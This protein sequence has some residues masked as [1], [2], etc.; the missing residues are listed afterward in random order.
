MIRWKAVIPVSIIIL[1]VLIGYIVFI[2]VIVKNIIVGT[3]QKITK[4]K[5]DVDDVTV[6]L[7]DSSVTIKGFAAARRDDPWKNLCEIDT[8]VIDLRL[9]ALFS[10]S[11]IIDELSAT[12]VRWGTTRTTSGALPV[13]IQK[14]EKKKTKK[15][16][17]FKVTLPL[18]TLKK[19]G[20]KIDVTQLVDVDNLAVVKQARNIETEIEQKKN[21]WQNTVKKINTY[22]Q[23][24]KEVRNNIKELQSIKKIESVQDVLAAQQAL[25]A[26]Q[27]DTKKLKELKNDVTE[28]RERVQN[29]VQ[30]LK[31]R[32]NELNEI[33]KKD[34]KEVFDMLGIGEIGMSNVGAALFGPVIVERITTLLDWL[35]RVRGWL[36]KKKEKK[37]IQ[38]RKRLKGRDIIFP[39]T[40]QENPLPGLLVH[41]LSFSGE[42]AQKPETQTLSLS[43]RITDITSNPRLY[44]KPIRITAQGRIPDIKNSDVSITGVMDY[45][46][47]LY[48]ENFQFTVKEY[49]LAD[50]T[51]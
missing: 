23:E 44:G 7:R 4:A 8:A 5:V 31:K 39:K 30:F 45:T 1:L 40:K 50:M 21:S 26:V 29:D 42:S 36:P 14:E 10:K 12:G 3:G 41:T 17:K 24:I 11:I 15:K 27:Q 35:D 13:T 33:K 2:D 32:I 37:K 20:K 6:R 9:M 49:P 48:R 25:Q 51:W 28:I 18:D 43:G 19:F 34:Y 47:D 22:E 38:E 46:S 16:K